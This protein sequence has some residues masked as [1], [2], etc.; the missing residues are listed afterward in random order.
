MTA[1][2][3]CPPPE[4]A[5]QSRPQQQSGARDSLHLLAFI[6]MHVRAKKEVRVE[7][8]A[9]QSG[10]LMHVE[11]FMCINDADCLAFEL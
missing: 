8:L 7:N 3:L 6:V 5:L 9:V 10:T 11:H 4:G 2:S 1:E